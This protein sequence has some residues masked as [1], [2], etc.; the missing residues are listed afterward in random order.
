M[1]TCRYVANVIA[2]STASGSGPRPFYDFLEGCLRHKVGGA[3]PHKRS[4][5][6][7]NPNS[8]KRP[9]LSTLTP[10]KCTAIDA[11]NF[12]TLETLK[13]SWDSF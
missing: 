11:W 8:T 13:I 6:I 12:L 3:D 5:P 1:H 2:E 10:C 4:D 9:L 7:C